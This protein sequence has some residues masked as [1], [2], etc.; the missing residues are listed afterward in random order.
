MF[1][2]M[3]RSET[4][5]NALSVGQIAER[6]AVSISA[7]HFY[8]ANHLITST[9]NT[10]NQRRYTR[11]TLRRVAFIRAS[12]RVGVP[13]AEIGEAL[14]RLPEQRTPTPH[15]WEAL[16]AA[17]KDRLDERIDQL[18]RLRD[19][20]ANCIGCGCLSLN[21]CHLANPYD[22]MSKEGPGARRFLPGSP[23]PAPVPAIEPTM[24]STT[25]RS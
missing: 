6:S 9:R 5:F 7:L 23:R 10:G 21:T 16:S 4:S 1:G 2:R 24:S 18:I 12:Q 20:L 8:E 19:D 22:T 11:D 3:P 25:N 13:L 15:D 17:W 14:A